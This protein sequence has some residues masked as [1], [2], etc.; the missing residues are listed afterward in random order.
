M[1][2]LGQRS[3]SAWETSPPQNAHH[4]SEIKSAESSCAVDA[5]SIET[6]EDASNIETKED[7]SSSETKRDETNGNVLH[8]NAPTA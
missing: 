5:S 4:R 7:A 8:S 1:R 2:P 3:G 6:K